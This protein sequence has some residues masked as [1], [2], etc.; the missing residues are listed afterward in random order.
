MPT[1]ISAILVIVAFLMPGFIANRFL[2]SAYPSAEPSETRAILTAITFSCLNYAVLSWLL[3][4][5]WTKAWYENLGFLAGFTFFILFLAPVFIAWL[6]IKF[7]Q[8]DW[9]RKWRLSLGLMHPMPKAW[10]YFFH[11]RK[12]CW[13]VATLKNGRIFAGYYGGNSFA[14]SFPAEEDLYLEKLCNLT[15]E[16]RILDLHPESAGGIIRM[17]AIDALEF[18]DS[19][20]TT[21]NSGG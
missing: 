11:L 21:C 2:A 8:S 10:D 9:G 3:I 7:V 20:P 5:F 14:S 15:P 13:V 12:P 6:F 17:D 4:L 19:H 16:G 18:F 1:T